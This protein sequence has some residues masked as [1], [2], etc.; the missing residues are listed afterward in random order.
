MKKSSIIHLGFIFIIAGISI[1]CI[2]NV[3][4]SI[5]NYYDDIGKSKK[6][7]SE[8]NEDYKIFKESILNVKNSIV[9]VSKTL[10]IYL[11]EFTNKNTIINQKIIKIEEEILKIN[12]PSKRLINNCKYNL[13]NKT[14]IS[15]C[16][17]FK[18]NYKN[19]ADSYIEMIKEY[20]KVIKSYNVYAKKINNKELPLYESKIENNIII[21]KEKIG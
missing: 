6:I 17:S 13:N 8:V 5:K 15:K 3:S 4:A 12:E 21:L 7:V 2:E 10:N 11:E 14:M 1:I 9:D 19:M 20:N 16:Q 18:T